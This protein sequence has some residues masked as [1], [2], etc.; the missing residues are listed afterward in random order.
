MV[1]AA[2]SGAERLAGVSG[3]W[4]FL[5]LPDGSAKDASLTD[6]SAPWQYV[7]AIW[8]YVA[9]Q[10]DQRFDVSVRGSTLSQELRA[11]TTAFLASANNFMV[12]AT[13]LSHLTDRQDV[14]VAS[15]FASGVTC[16]VS[17]CTSNLPMGIITSLGPNIFLASIVHSGRFTPGGA[18]AVS[19]TS[20]ALLLLMAV[21]PV[22]NMVLKMVPLYI[23]YGLV[24]GT[25][26]FTALKAVGNVVEHDSALAF[27]HILSLKCS[28][29]VVFLILVASLTHLKVKNAMIVGMLGGTCAYWILSGHWP[30]NF[31]DLHSIKPVVPDFSVLFAGG[32]RGAWLQVVSLAFLVLLTISGSLIG[33]ADM[34]NLLQSNG[35][36]PGG[37]AVYACCGL[38]TVL[39]A[40]LGCSPVFVSMS[41]SSGIKE[42]G[43]TGLM[44]IV[45]GVYCLLTAFFLSPLASAIPH[46][47][48]SPILILVGIHMFQ[49]VHNV[50]WNNLAEALPAFLCV[51]IQP[52]TSSVQDGLYAGL[53]FSF[54]LSMTTGAFLAFLPERFQCWGACKD[55]QSLTSGERVAYMDC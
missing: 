50:N 8:K 38:G 34:A 12:N 15:A 6:G 52:Y 32:A 39:S 14:V 3:S 41:A 48:I 31:V 4:P 43:R 54:I 20:G 11:G 30:H 5:L 21:T 23:K 35:D 16:I 18:F 10:L 44:A 28:I 27:T 13:I 45:L 46:C 37:R 55:S 24:I 42:G 53:A 26:L 9:A 51:I 17:G 47:A 22:L 33:S 1:S 2:V 7:S 36:V 49:Q 25:G 29:T 19:A 40:F